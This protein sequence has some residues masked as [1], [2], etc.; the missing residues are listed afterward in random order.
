M[1]FLSS[2]RLEKVFIIQDLAEQIHPIKQQSSY[3]K[4]TSFFRK[5]RA[6]F[7]ATSICTAI[8]GFSTQKQAKKNQNPIP[9]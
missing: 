7:S 3:R 9:D 1:G 6:F 8:Q 5:K 2:M 4:E